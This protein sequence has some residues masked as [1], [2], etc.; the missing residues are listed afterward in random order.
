VQ[1]TQSNEPS[2]TVVSYAD[3]MMSTT[4]FEWIVLG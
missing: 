2:G 4:D 3:A 1:R